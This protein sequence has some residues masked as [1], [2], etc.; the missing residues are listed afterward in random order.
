MMYRGGGKGGCWALF[1]PTRFWTPRLLPSRSTLC[2][3]PHLSSSVLS[4]PRWFN[5]PFLSLLRR[6]PP[7]THRVLPSAAADFCLRADQPF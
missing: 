3:S 7:L 1:C 4:L 5:C 6:P 2:L